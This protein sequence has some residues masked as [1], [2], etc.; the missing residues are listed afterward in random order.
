MMC[1]LVINRTKI[2][3]S[4]GSGEEVLLYFSYKMFNKLIQVDI[5]VYK[6]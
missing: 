4:E 3:L 6:L 2:H 5:Y 1:D